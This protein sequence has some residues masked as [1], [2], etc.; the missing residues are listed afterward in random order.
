[1]DFCA[2]HSRFTVSGALLVFIVVALLLM[3]SP[4]SDAVNWQV[5]VKKY[6]WCI[7]CH[8]VKERTHFY[9]GRKQCEMRP[10]SQE[11]QTAWI[12]KQE[13]VAIGGPE[14]RAQQVAEER[15]NSQEN[16]TPAESDAPKPFVMYFGKH[17]KRSISQ[18]VQRDPDYFAHL[19]L[20][21]AFANRPLLVQELEKENVLDRIRR[22][23]QELKILVAAAVVEKEAAGAAV[24]MHPEVQKLH[25]IKLAE[26][27]LVL[28]DEDV[29]SAGAPAELAMA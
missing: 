23:A 16:T 1:M 15:R 4:G 29:T 18:V 10:L 28:R 27:E 20:Q 17:S 12:A 14:V 3:A 22:R 25:Q 5:K 2:A 11:E 7:A 6:R 8:G 9:T 19:C 13:Q 26:A 24:A 21:G